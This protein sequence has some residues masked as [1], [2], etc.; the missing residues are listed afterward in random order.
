MYTGRQLAP[1][2]YRKTNN[3]F[4]FENVSAKEI[5]KELKNLELKSCELSVSV[6]E[7]PDRKKKKKKKNLLSSKAAQD[8]DVPT[9][10]IKDNIDILTPI[11]LE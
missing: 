3:T 9:K 8:S 5:E 6:K 10:V 1:R 2:I 4:H 11:L 7:N